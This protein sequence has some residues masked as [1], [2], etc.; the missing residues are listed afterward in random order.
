VT[1]AAA[2]LAALLMYAKHPATHN[3]PRWVALMVPDDFL[4][5]AELALAAECTPEPASP[6]P[7]ITDADVPY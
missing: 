2:T 6:A 7:S 4:D 3:S 5:Q 1:P